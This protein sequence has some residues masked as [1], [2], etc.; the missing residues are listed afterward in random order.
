MFQ[1]FHFWF[2]INVKRSIVSNPPCASPSSCYWQHF[3]S[4]YVFRV[5]WR[6]VVLFWVKVLH[7]AML[8]EST[9][10]THIARASPKSEKKNPQIGIPNQLRTIDRS[11]L[12]RGDANIEKQLFYHNRSICFQGWT[13]TVVDFESDQALWPSL[14]FFFASNNASRLSVNENIINGALRVWAVP[15][16]E[17]NW[18]K[19]IDESS[20]AI[21]IL[22]RTLSLQN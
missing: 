16:Y 4:L 1:Q 2:D 22:L 9:T 8:G 21:D 13:M 5:I 20:D 7:K 3:S 6:V 14:G 15:K 17:K 10:K 18:A 19:L 12:M 11:H